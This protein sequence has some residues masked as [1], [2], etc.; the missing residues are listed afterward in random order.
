VNKP[1]QQR[2]RHDGYSRHEVVPAGGAAEL[3]R[4]ANRVRNNEAPDSNYFLRNVFL[5]VMLYGEI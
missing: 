4:S 2:G 5:G 1:L 3:T